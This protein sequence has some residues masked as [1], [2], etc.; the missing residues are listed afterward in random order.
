MPE[1][2]RRTPEPRTRQKES[3]SRPPPWQNG[4]THPREKRIKP[5]KAGT[6][7][8]YGKHKGLNLTF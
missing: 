5:I 2:R 3:K 4:K 8:E 6:T 7:D 1:A